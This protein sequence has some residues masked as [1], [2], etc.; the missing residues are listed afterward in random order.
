MTL[1]VRVLIILGLSIFITIILYEKETEVN[2]KVKG[3]RMESE[4]ID[5]ISN[6]ERNDKELY[7]KDAWKDFVGEVL[8]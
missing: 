4:M 6:S 2:D 3:I 1:V 7:S 8:E 5:R